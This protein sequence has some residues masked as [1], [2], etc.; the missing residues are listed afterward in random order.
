MYHR[1][2]W[3]MIRT[4]IAIGLALALTG[5]LTACSATPKDGEKMEADVRMQPV[6]LTSDADPARCAARAV[7][8][9]RSRLVADWGAAVETPT[10]LYVPRNARVIELVCVA[11]GG[12]T[13]TTRYLGSEESA[14]AKSGQAAT[15]AMFL[16]LGGLPALATGVAQRT[17]V[18]EFPV[19]VAVAL[20][21]AAGA[22]RAGFASRRGAEIERDTAEW[23]RLRW[24]MCEA[25]Q[26][27]GTSAMDDHCER[28]LAEIKKR[29]EQMSADL[30]ALQTAQN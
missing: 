21:P 30:R 27:P 29:K 5:A 8:M 11:A 7:L 25:E 13:A 15:G 1:A 10:T 14:E 2:G 4:K 12:G 6:A 23:H 16:L 3:G 26:S 19:A 9:H 24:A 28:G 18:Y 22:G 20:P 17:D